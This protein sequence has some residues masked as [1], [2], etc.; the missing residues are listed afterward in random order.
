MISEESRQQMLDRI[1]RLPNMVIAAVGGGSNAIGAFAHYLS[2]E[3]GNE[4]VQLVGVEPAG[5]GLDS[6]KHGAP[7]ERGKVG[8][9]HGSKSYVLLGESGE[10]SESYS[11]SA[12]LD[13]Q[14][15]DKNMLI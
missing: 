14:V 15:W 4:D 13:Y 11:I 3:P 6:G 1:G 2:D 12:G 9:L 5:E 8:V 7:L 10:V